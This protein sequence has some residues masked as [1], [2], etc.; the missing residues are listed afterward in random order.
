[1]VKHKTAVTVYVIKTQLQFF[2]I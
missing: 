1:M 2:F